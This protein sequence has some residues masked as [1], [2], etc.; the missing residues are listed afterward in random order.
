MFQI[1]AV[2]AT[3]LFFILLGF[4]VFVSL[5]ITGIIFTLAMGV[6]PA[7]IPIKIF[8]SLDSFALLAIPFFII[9]GNL[10]TMGKITNKLVDLANSVVGH[11]KGGLG[12][13]NILSSALFGSIQGSG[14]ADASAIGGIL[15][16]T[17]I[18]QG[19]SPQYSVAV[20]VASSLLSPIVPPSIAMILYSYYTDLPVGTLFLA[21]YFPGIILLIGMMLLNYFFC[22]R[23]ENAVFTAKFTWHGLWKSLVNSVG[24]LVMP[25]IIVSGIIFGIV[26]PTEAGILAVIYGLIYGLFISR[27]LDARKILQALINSAITTSVVM[28]TIAAAGLVGNVLVRMRFQ[29]QMLHF[30]LSTIGH[31]YISTFFVIL[32]L[33]MFGCFLDPTVLIAMF[34]PTVLSIGNALGFN[35]IHY[36]IVMIIVMQMGAITPPVGTFLFISCSIAKLPLEKS[37]KPLIPF[38]VLIILVVVMALYVPWITTVIPSLLGKL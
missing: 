8:G 26:S 21:G 34:A 9:A 10:M 11:L 29:Q 5:L 13:V 19:Y 25:I 38:L 28:M 27:E 31:P 37:I 17:M 22:S 23:A 7:L 18:E 3:M 33:L 14:A 24:A 6:P 35:P 1:L 15:I 20:T 4:P 16:P 2:F 36:G 12:H 30:A 32:L